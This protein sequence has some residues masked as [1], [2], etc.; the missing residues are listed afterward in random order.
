MSRRVGDHQLITGVGTFVGD[1]VDGTT[2]HCWF[3]RSPLAHA[4]VTSV[5][6]DSALQMSG[7][8]GVW[9]AEDLDLPD[10]PANPSDGA[11]AQNMSRPPIAGE[12]VRYVG[13]P[14]AAVVASSARQAEDAAE[15]VWVELEDLPVAVT[16]EEALAGT[17]RL[18][19]GASSNIVSHSVLEHGEQPS[20]RPSVSVTVEVDSPRLA[21]VPIEPLAI[22]AGPEGEGIRVWCGHQAPH[23]LRDQ[24]AGFLGLPAETVRVTVP[25][26]GGAFG[27]KGMLYPEYLVVAKLALET[28]SRVAWIQTRRE[29]FSG[30]THGRSQHHKVT[31]EGDTQGRLSRA[32]IE[33]L[34]DTGAYPHNGSL[35]P[36]FTRLVA[37][38]LYDIPRLEVETT[39]LVTNR[40]P[41]GSYRGA[42]RPEAALAIERA[43]DAFAGAAGIDPLQVRMVNLIGP[44]QLPHRTGT[45]ALYDSGDYPAAL[46]KAMDL[47]DLPYWRQEQA[48]RLE[49]GES[50]IGIG[51]G[52]FVERAGGAADS[53]EYAR[54]EVSPDDHSIVVRT[55]STDSGQ[56]H[57]TVW[58]RLASDL[59]GVD[60]VVVVAGD[61]GEVVKGVG[62]FASRSAQIGASAVV[63]VAGA[64][65]DVARTRAASRL[66]A[67]V[68]DLVY[69]AGVF[70]VVG[71]PDIEVSL[72]DLAADDE[73]AA[74][75][76]YSPGAQTFPYGVHAAVVEVATD[77]GEVVVLRII[78]VDDCGVV[79]DPMIVEGQ[80]H[81]SLA[82][83]LGQALFEEV[84]YD[85]NGQLLTGTLVDYLLPTALEI[86]PIVTGRL[87]HRAPSNPLGVKG[88]GEAG[89]IG[90]PPAILNAVIDALTPLGIDDLQLPL[91][92]A[93]VWAAVEAARTRP[94]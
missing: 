82:Q 35:I 46:Q 24:L 16:T 80:L 12:T 28:G 86:P 61:T 39:T 43:I 32:R 34:S 65:L 52:A 2:L 68:A 36:M 89:C 31:L 67:S 93:R 21:P 18:F 85:T 33:I 45:G 11:A 74:E 3:V 10:I 58:G 62:S 8:V 7:V 40:A 20:V 59:F 92:P 49:T 27:M 23:R 37:T 84:R 71:S 56:G 25:S 30:G 91:T 76:M 26:V 88:A 47:L 55:G 5:D 51:V 81:G 64:V 90:L 87:Q 38:G 94:T 4:R 70:S 50:L 72:W 73:L 63:R 42:G 22:V 1:L 6:R 44:S 19:S 53:G 48:R 57:S 77:T 9:A 75:E 14:I 78:A 17:V 60:D 83:G 54:V 41:T 69:E 13:E 66:E 79:L 29:Q 15:R